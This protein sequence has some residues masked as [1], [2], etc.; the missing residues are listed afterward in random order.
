MV[1]RRS[2]VLFLVQSADH[3]LLP[4]WSEP[5]RRGWTYRKGIMGVVCVRG[6]VLLSPRRL[7]FRT[8]GSSTDVALREGGEAAESL[9]GVRPLGN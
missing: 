7:S 6:D 2:R 4:T 5:L 1:R 3:G 9:A 8:C